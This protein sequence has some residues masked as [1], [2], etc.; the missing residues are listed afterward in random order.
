MDLDRPT[1][2][3]DTEA[4][5][6]EAEHCG[7]HEFKD[8]LNNRLVAALRSSESARGRMEE[9]LRFYRDQWTFH[10]V[11]DEGDGVTD[12]GRLDG[13]EASPTSALLKDGGDLARAAVSQGVIRGELWSASTAI[14]QREGEDAS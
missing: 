11:G 5:L 12:L 3:Q 1:M 10:A 13:Y 8:S 6:A 7:R 9:A 4:V 14:A 2:T